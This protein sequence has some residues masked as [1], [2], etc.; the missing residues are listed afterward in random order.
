MIKKMEDQFN[1]TMSN[2][3]DEITANHYLAYRPPL[4]DIILKKCLKNLERRKKGL[5]IGSGT[6]HSALALVEF[7]DEVIG[8]EPSLA[9]R[10]IALPHI[11]IQYC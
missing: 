11:Q 6:G 5:D 2:D 10:K 7:C 1:G 9:M 3:Y 4:H 8:I